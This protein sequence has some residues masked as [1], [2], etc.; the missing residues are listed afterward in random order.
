MRSVVTIG[1][2]KSL[3]SIDR[4][5]V[6]KTGT[7]NRARDAWFVGSLPDIAFGAWVG[8]DA[9]QALGGKESGGRTAVPIIKAYI[10]AAEMDGPGWSEAPDGVV[11]KTIAKPDRLAHKDSTSGRKE[12]FLSGT[13]PIEYAVADGELDR[14]DFHFDREDPD[15]ELDAPKDTVDQ[16]VDGHDPDLGLSPIPPV[17]DEDDVD[18]Q[19]LDLSPID[20][21]EAK[22]PNS[23]QP[24]AALGDEPASPKGPIPQNEPMDDDEEDRPEPN[25]DPAGTIQTDEEDN[26]DP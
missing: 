3:K 16:G 21:L 15:L 4:E 14:D 22:S 8:F 26:P 6:G 1:S 25:S 11:T 10:Q 24:N 20:P 5:I 2:A 12:V 19:E 9:G 13:E 17:G 7:T 23:V 18:D